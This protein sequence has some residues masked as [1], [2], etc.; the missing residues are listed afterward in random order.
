VDLLGS[1]RK[2]CEF[3]QDCPAADPPP[4]SSAF[5]TASSKRSI[6]CEAWNSIPDMTDWR[7]G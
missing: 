4:P 2:A 5:S 1:G 3:F 6:T 7:T